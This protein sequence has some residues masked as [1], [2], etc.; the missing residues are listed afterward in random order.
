VLLEAD[1][2]VARMR[3]G[4][5]LEVVGDAVVR[6]RVAALAAAARTAARTAAGRFSIFTSVMFGLSLLRPKVIRNGDEDEE[7]LRRTGS[8]S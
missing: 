1:G 6:E 7:N 5:D 2:D 3:A 8:W 4:I